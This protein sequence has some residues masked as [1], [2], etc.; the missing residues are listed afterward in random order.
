MTLFLTPNAGTKSPAQKNAP[1]L[2]PP[3]GAAHQA[4]HLESPKGQLGCLRGLEGAGC[5][6]R[7]PLVT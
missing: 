6:S 7:W 5:M 1:F 3:L 2:L 4:P